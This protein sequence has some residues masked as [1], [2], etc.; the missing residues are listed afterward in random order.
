[1]KKIML[2]FF[3]IFAF[4]NSIEINNFETD[5]YSKS[6]GLK[7]ITLSLKII[8]DNVNNENDYIQDSINM[9]ISSYYYEDLFTE[10]GK[11]N[12]KKT[13]IKY[14]GKKYSVNNVSYTHMTQ[15]TNR[16]VYF[17]WFVHVV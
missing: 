10:L 14:A 6:N 13:I 15:P 9:V 1:M 16:E 5:L 17:A 3:S 8:G 12:L 2:I 4:A 7:K 11:E